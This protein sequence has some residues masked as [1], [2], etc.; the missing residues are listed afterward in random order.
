MGSSG[1]KCPDPWE[2]EIAKIG[3]EFS[4]SLEINDI[5]VC[6]YNDEN[7][8]PDRFLGIDGHLKRNAE[9]LNLACDIVDEKITY[10]DA[11][12]ELKAFNESLFNE[13]KEKWVQ[14]PLWNL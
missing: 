7:A 12:K 9:I 11:I 8:K 13:S 3:Q 2:S 4:R 6:L 1:E 10:D 14:L 5:R